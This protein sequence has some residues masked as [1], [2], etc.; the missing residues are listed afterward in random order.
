MMIRI[1]FKRHLAR[2][3]DIHGVVSSVKQMEDRFN[4]KF[5]YDYVLLNDQPF[6]DKFKRCVPLIPHRLLSPQT[7]AA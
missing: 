5:G 3:S 2:N 1:N 6:E 4:K 7:F